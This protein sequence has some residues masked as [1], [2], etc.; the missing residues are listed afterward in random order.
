MVRQRGRPILRHLGEGGG[1]GMS[2][3]LECCGSEF[4]VCLSEWTYGHVSRNGH[5]RG[6]GLN[7]MRWEGRGHWHQSL[8]AAST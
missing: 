2:A 7:G 3:M 5:S 6:C 1:G 4:Q 8:G